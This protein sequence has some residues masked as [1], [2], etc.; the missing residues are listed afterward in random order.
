VLKLLGKEEGGPEDL[1]GRAAGGA[2]DSSGEAEE[3][4][5]GATG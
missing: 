4:V 1:G 5:R 2:S 3:I